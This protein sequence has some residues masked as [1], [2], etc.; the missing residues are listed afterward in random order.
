MHASGNG[1][2]GMLFYDTRWHLGA[3]DFVKHSGVVYCGNHTEASEFCLL[4]CCGGYVY[5]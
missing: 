4:T 5:S 2:R 3:V 1:E